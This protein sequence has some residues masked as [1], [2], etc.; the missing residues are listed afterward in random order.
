MST[1]ERSGYVLV[2]PGGAR[3]GFCA[4][5]R[6]R[7][8]PPR[9]RSFSA[10]QRRPQS[11]GG[12]RLPRPPRTT[13]PACPLAGCQERLPRLPPR[14][15]TATRAARGFEGTVASQRDEAHLRRP[16]HRAGDGR[17][18]ARRGHLRR[19]AWS[20]DGRRHARPPPLPGASSREA[21]VAA[22]PNE[23]TSAAA[24]GD[25]PPPPS[26]PPPPPPSPPAPG[27]RGT[28]PPHD[29]PPRSGHRAG[30]ADSAATHDEATS[31]ARGIEPGTLAVA[32]TH[33]EA[34]SAARGI[35]PGTLAVAATHDGPTSAA[36][37]SSRERWRLPQRTTRPPSPPAGS[38]RRPL[39]GD[40]VQRIE[41]R[42]AVSGSDRGCQHRRG[43]GSLRVGSLGS[44][45]RVSATGAGGRVVHPPRGRPP[46]A[47]PRSA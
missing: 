34:T 15:T 16:G 3:T 9:L 12:R 28:V 33:D 43:S 5:R 29:E 1:P 2:R 26:P 18:H 10:S 45:F 39:H 41:V 42:S 37:A 35:E 25:G 6:R 30:N 23:A 32:A 21:T 36:R 19:R 14:A 8:W 27:D 38:V 44:H 31:A 22:T 17:R 13:K 47:A 40:R 20:S 7:S 4:G 24:H 11:G 46:S